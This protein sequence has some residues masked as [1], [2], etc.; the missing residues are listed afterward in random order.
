MNQHDELRAMNYRKARQRQ[1]ELQMEREKQWAKHSPKE[2]K[3]GTGRVV[4]YTVF[5]VGLVMIG[6]VAFNAEQRRI[7][8][9]RNEELQRQALS[10]YESRK[11]KGTYRKPYRKPTQAPKT[12]CVDLW[13]VK[14]DGEKQHKQTGEIVYEAVEGWVEVP[15][16]CAN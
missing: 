8:N 4:G 14:I 7:A 3:R 16:P 11:S 9:E 10:E 15:V 5:W 6:L 1:I 13:W 2:G 12:E